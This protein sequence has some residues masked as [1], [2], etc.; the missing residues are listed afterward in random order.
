[1]NVSVS[2]ASTKAGPQTKPKIIDCDVHPLLKRPADLKKYLAREW[3]AHFDEYGN[4]LRM[5]YAAGDLYPKSAPFISRR[6][7][8][9]PS[10][11]P[12]GSDLDFMREQLLDLFDIE[13]GILQV[14]YPNGASQRN[15][16]YGS[17]I[18]SALNDWQIA[19]W[20]EPEPR[21]KGSLVVGNDNVEHAVAEIHKHGDD[22]RFVQI[23]FSP[24]S[25]EP[26]GRR[27]YW[28]IYRA[29]VEHDLSIGLHTH[30][31]NGHPSVPGGGWCSYYVEH[32]QLVSIGMQ[33]TLASLIME[34]VFEEFPTLRVMFIEGGFSWV[35]AFLWRL[36]RLWE[37]LRSEVPHVKRR[38]SDYVKINCWFSTQP[39]E[40]VNEPDHLR[41]AID[42]L[43]WDRLCFSTDYP[44]WDFD[45][46]RYAFP[47]R[48]SNQEQA[49]V[50][51]NNA[52]RFMN[53][54]EEP[55]A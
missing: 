4:F 10:G 33:A 29:A 28:P 13:L 5:P 18:T 41:Q 26:I 53:I 44:H 40:D 15:L 1:M 19:E 8:Y 20:I 49:L 54:P 11:G 12:P 22:K 9:P 7:A 46:P 17:A 36:D 42:W 3:H 43:G 24:R 34:G 51:R 31:H 55:A 14:L 23:S 52:L 37:R 30:G 16:A 39:M 21:L 38:P 2:S 48:M 50:F 47:F 45:D 35:P 25:I 6:D 32:H 27:R